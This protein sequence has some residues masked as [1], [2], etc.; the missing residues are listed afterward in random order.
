MSSNCVQHGKI[1]SRAQRHGGGAGERRCAGQPAFGGKQIAAVQRSGQHAETQAQRIFILSPRQTDHQQQADQRQQQRPLL[2]AGGPLPPQRR[3]QQHEGRSEVQQQR[4]SPCTDTCQGQKIG[5]GGEAVQQAHAQ[6]A[7]PQRPIDWPPAPGQQQQRHQSES[8]RQ[9]R[10][11]GQPRQGRELAQN[12]QA[13]KSQGR[14]Q[15]QQHAGA[16]RSGRSR[17]GK[18]RRGVRHDRQASSL[19]WASS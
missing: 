19:L 5:V 9:R 6:H 3:I 7:R 16:G 14:E 1:D 18:G 8:P 17:A 15:R 13:G 10:E 12:A 2:R 4:G 11:C